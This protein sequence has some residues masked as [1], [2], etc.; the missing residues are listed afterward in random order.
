[1]TLALQPAATA[2]IAVHWQHDIVSPDGAFGPV[3]APEVARTGAVERAG[4]LLRAAREAGVRIVYTQ[5]GYRPGHDDLLANCPLLEQVKAAGA[6][7]EGAPGSAIIDELAPQGSDVV[8]THRRISGFTGSELDTLLRGWGVDTVVMTGV[9]TNV[10]VEGTARDATD[11]GYTTF[12]VADAC[13]AATPEAHDAS[14]ATLGLL[15]HVTT[16]DDVMVALL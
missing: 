6:A 2:V 3:F 12:V 14:L 9:A 10:S 5:V 7:E 15:G 1:M 8:V 11:R 16:V 4:R 13:A